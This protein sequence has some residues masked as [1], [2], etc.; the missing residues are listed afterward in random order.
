VGAA[1]AS[2]TAPTG[3]VL[4]TRDRDVHLGPGS[5]V[6][7]LDGRRQQLTSGRVM[8]DARRGPGLELATDAALV[9]T[10]EGVLSRVEQRALL[11]VGAFDGSS[12]RARVQVQPTGRRA[13][14][15]LA[16]WTQSQVPVGGCPAGSPRW[17]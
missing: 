13:L 2:V 8:V 15:E 14:T 6:T 3:A 12:D 17:C 4:R 1:G 11:R 10:P 7:V 16:R 5:S 9:T